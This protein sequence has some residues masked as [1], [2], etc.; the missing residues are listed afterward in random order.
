MILK[1]CLFVVK[2]F[3]GLKG[4]PL[5]KSLPIGFLF[6]AELFRFLKKEGK[7]TEELINK[8]LKWRHSGFSVDNGVRIKKENREGTEAIALFGAASFA[9]HDAKCFQYIKHQLYRKNR[10]S[11]LPYRQNSK[12]EK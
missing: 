7:I 4:W 1:I 8:L 9:P 3:F 12:G 5:P 10:K 2:V 11:D 6:R